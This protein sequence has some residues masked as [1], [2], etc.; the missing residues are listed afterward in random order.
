MYRMIEEQ[1]VHAIVL[2]GGRS[3]RM[4]GQHKPG[5]LVDGRTIVDRT[6][7]TVWSAIPTAQVV[8][9]GSE[10][11]LSPNLQ[12]HVSL[13]REDPPFSGPLAGVAAAIE[14]IAASDG[15]VILLGGDLPFLSA[16]TLRRLLATA[17]AGAP[18]A[19]CLDATGHLQYLCAAWQQDV[20]RAQL[21]RVGDPAGVPLKALFDSLSAELIDCD[22]DELRDVDT[23]G[24]LARAVTT[25]DGRPVPESLLATVE[26][27][28][29]ERGDNAVELSPQ[30]TAQILEFA[31][32][33]K[34]SPSAANPV[35]AAFLAG[36]LAGSSGDGSVL[37]ALRRVLDLAGAGGELGNVHESA[38]RLA[39]GSDVGGLPGGDQ[40]TGQIHGHGSS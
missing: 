19:S 31:R 6:V 34:Y 1:P 15:T 20:L 38:H 21:E 18:V 32:A 11:G 30:E 36:Q 28:R 16:K 17:T 26:N 12:Q 40:Q 9:A 8:I 35:V 4:G 7:S 37:D 39:G 25:P 22:P 24:D 3:S 27:L 14:A 10:A 29:A 33:V 13:V 2:T 23:P 5:I